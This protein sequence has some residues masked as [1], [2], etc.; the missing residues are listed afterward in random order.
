[1]SLPLWRLPL[2]LCRLAKVLQQWVLESSVFFSLLL[3]LLTLAYIIV[4]AFK[5]TWDLAFCFSPP[6][7][8]RPEYTSSFRMTTVWVN[9]WM[10]QKE[11]KRFNEIEQSRIRCPNTCPDKDLCRVHVNKIIESPMRD[12]KEDRRHGD[13]LPI[14]LDGK[15]PT[16]WVYYITGESQTAGK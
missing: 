15:I 12:I 5:R 10:K 16:L 6:S 13:S 2:G 4:S 7:R 8:S 1:M 3:H 9:T 14:F 11:T